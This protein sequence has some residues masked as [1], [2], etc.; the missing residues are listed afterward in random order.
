MFVCTAVVSTPHSRDA[1]LPRVR[2]ANAANEGWLALPSSV[3]PPKMISS[4][5]ADWLL[6]KRPLAVFPLII[7]PSKQGRG[8]G[9]PTLGD[10]YPI[11]HRVCSVCSIAR[12]ALTQIPITRHNKPRDKMRPTQSEERTTAP[13]EQ[14]SLPATPPVSLSDESTLVSLTHRDAEPELY[15]YVHTFNK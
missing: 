12:R 2:K 14:P 8:G 15:M 10:C 9:A 11:V 13:A 1:C 7:L 4:R 3:I 5:A 6:R